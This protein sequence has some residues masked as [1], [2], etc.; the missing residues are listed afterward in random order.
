MVQ[1]LGYTLFAVDAGAKY[2]GFTF[3]GEYYFRTLSDFEA[4]GEL[5][6]SSI[7]DHGLMAQAMHMVVPKRVGIY[8]SGGY[9][10]D[11]FERNPW[12]LGGGVSVYPSGTR[13][14]RLN[15]HVMQ[16]EKS[17]ASSTFGYY[18]A[19]QSGTIISVGTDILM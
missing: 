9:V 14:W 5:P 1:R 16:I 12:E 4:D 2:R 15:L 17:P 10:F 3:Q 6:R 18:T 7:Y 8:A 13:T 11:D 19:G